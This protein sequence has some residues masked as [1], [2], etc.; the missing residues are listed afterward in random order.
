MRKILVGGYTD[1]VYVSNLYEAIINETRSDNLFYCFKLSKTKRPKESWENERFLF[2]KFVPFPFVLYVKSLLRIPILTI[3]RL[4]IVKIAMGSKNPVTH[5]R[6]I[7]EQVHYYLWAYYFEKVLK[8][9]VFH[10]H[11]IIPDYLW[12]SYYFTSNVKIIYSIWGSDLLRIAN[13]YAYKMSFAALQGADSIVVANVNLREFL[14]VKFGHNLQAKVSLNYFILSERIFN[15]IDFYSGKQKEISNLKKRFKISLD[16]RVIIIG[17]SGD[18]A[19]QHMEILRHFENKA[20]SKQLV[21]I[22]PL[23]YGLTEEYEK[24]LIDYQSTSSLDIILQTDFLSFDDLAALKL[25]AD[26]VVMTPIS[27]GNSAFLIESI[28]AGSQCIVGSWLPYGRMIEVG[29]PLIEISALELIPERVLQVN[30]SATDRDITAIRK[31]IRIEYLSRNIINKW[32]T[33]LN[34]QL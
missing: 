7:K 24:Q 14:L 3:L 32:N 9:D 2:E 16:K 1:S 8:I 17:H 13:P 15:R 22:L 21:F 26:Y 20:I 25:A 5:L 4:L 19:D 11:T 30:T 31:I 6:F 27:D 23:S 18:C 29:L 28:Y 34:N 12:I 10:C 33:I